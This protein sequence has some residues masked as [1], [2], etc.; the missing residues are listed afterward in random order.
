[1]EHAQYHGACRMQAVQSRLVP[2]RVVP[3]GTADLAAD[4][5]ITVDRLRL[6]SRL[7]LGAAGLGEGQLKAGRWRLRAEV[8]VSV[9]DARHH[10]TAP[11][12]DHHRR[13][14]D[15]DCDDRVLTHRDDAA[16]AY[17]QGAGFRLERVAGPDP[18]LDQQ[19]LA[20]VQ[21]QGETHANE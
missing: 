3:Q 5:A 14:G 1:G 11:E 8:D 18:A 17:P 19:Q 21:R 20:G 13:A 15:V 6:Q 16:V 10:A 4:P 7:D 12:V 9:V 2:V